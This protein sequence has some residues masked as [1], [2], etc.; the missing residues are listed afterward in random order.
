MV[1]NGMDGRQLQD[2]NCD[3]ISRGNTA[4]CHGDDGGIEGGAGGAGGQRDARNGGRNWQ[5]VDH[6]RL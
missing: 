1:A 4:V 2:A 5:A 3:R 6:S